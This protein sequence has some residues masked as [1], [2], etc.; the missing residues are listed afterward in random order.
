MT[1]KIRQTGKALIAEQEAWLTYR[2]NCVTVGLPVLMPS[3]LTIRER[4]EGKKNGGRKPRRTNQQIA[5]DAARG[6]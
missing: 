5:A 1:R 6:E 4:A 2:D 3:P